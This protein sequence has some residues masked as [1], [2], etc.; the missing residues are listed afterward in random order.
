[1]TI[2]RNSV[3]YPRLASPEAMFK[4]FQLSFDLHQS[5]QELGSF[6]SLL[7][8]ARR[9]L[10]KCDMQS[11]LYY[12]ILLWKSYLLQS[13]EMSS[14]AEDW[15]QILH[16]TKAFLIIKNQAKPFL[17][18]NQTYSF[19][20]VFNGGSGKIVEV[21]TSWLVDANFKHGDLEQNEQL[22]EFFP[23]ASDYFPASMNRQILVAHL[24][25]EYCHRWNKDRPHLDM[26]EDCVQSLINIGNPEL[27]H[28]LTRLLWNVILSKPTK[29]AVNLTEIRSASRCEREMGFSESDIPQFLDK[30]CDVLGVHQKTL[31]ES[32]DLLVSYDVTN[33]DNAGAQRHLIDILSRL[34]VNYER[35]SIFG[36]F[37]Q[38]AI[39][40]K[41]IWFF[42]L[43]VKP[44]TL[45]SNQEVSLFFQ[46]GLPG[47]P[48][49]STWSSWAISQ[50][51]GVRN[52]R[53]RFLEI[54]CQGAVQTIQVIS[55]SETDSEDYN[56]WSELI[57]IL[58]MHWN[59]VDRLSEVRIVAM[60]KAGYD[61]LGEEILCTMADKETISRKLL[62]IA[63][64]R[65]SKNLVMAESDVNLQA[66]LKVVLGDEVK[67]TV[68]ELT[69]EIDDVALVELGQTANLLVALT[70][71]DLS[72]VD[73]QTVYD[74]L[75]VAQTLIRSQS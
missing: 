34:Q 40:S 73:Q 63:M 71:N 35:D 25:W 4:L 45:F 52:A 15:N 32:G 27:E 17:I 33:C 36:L 38:M 61:S 48:K 60:Y 62:R 37:H 55:E 22:K 64:L 18:T 56:K 65:L 24:S 43:D 7:Q 69:S 41:I 29:D 16:F 50:N 12:T 42:G 19:N 21:I 26:L 51:R 67:N 72:D 8:I 68:K 30:I 28:R 5:D 57:G 74:W 9:H 6:Q 54:T 10:V 53:K 2:L 39:V 58:A 47:E 49:A 59:M 13:Q 11:K 44:L 75:A 14:Y 23:V 3:E 31:N 70:N 66:K 20:E 46:S 1:M